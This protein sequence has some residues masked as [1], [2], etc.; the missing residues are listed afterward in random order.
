MN[1]RNIWLALLFV[2][3]S[4]GPIRAGEHRKEAVAMIENIHWLGHA[5]FKIT[6]KKVIYIDPWMLKKGDPADYI[7]ITH[8]HF[9]HLSID[10]INKI[11]K[12]DTIIVTISA[13][14]QELKGNV[15]VIKPGDTLTLN[16]IT[17]EAVPAYNMG[18]NFH[19]KDDRN[20]GF[21]F[22]IEGTR[23]Y[24][25]GD[26]DVI[27]EMENMRADIALLPVGGKYTMDAESAAKVAQKV[28]AKIAVPMHWG[29]LQ[30]VAGKEAAEK[31]KTLLKGKMDVKILSV[32]K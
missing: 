21:I 16:G 13:V 18:K 15:K 25:A 17:V 2:I 32:E 11:S 24:H 4:L 14:A 5:S 3:V 9:D 27:P 29:A 26:T 8:G 30:D 31:L 7:F 10:D 1:Y 6:G 20:V 28:K 23:I 22:T 19:P 12:K